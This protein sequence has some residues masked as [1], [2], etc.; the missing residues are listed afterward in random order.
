MSN[1][2]FYSDVVN[3]KFSQNESHYVTLEERLNENLNAEWEKSMLF[4]A[5]KN[6]E[7]NNPNVKKFEDLDLC[8]SFNIKLSDVM[9]DTTL[10]RML[11][12]H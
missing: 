11:T 8:E 12:L 4:N 5:Q 3:K 2:F 9:I 10:Q 7:R 6:F 1:T